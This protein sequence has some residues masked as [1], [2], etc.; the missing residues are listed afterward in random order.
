MPIC[1]TITNIF[2]PFRRSKTLRVYP[3][4]PFPFTFHSNTF[5]LGITFKNYFIRINYKGF[6]PDNK[7][8]LL[9]NF[10]CNLALSL[11]RQSLKFLSRQIKILSF[12]SLLCICSLK[13]KFCNRASSLVLDQ[14][15]HES[16]LLITFQNP[17]EASLSISVYTKY[18]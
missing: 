18:N 17:G 13:L 15:S 12:N 7:G 2:L 10:Q 8:G 6:Y 4:K 9:R 11:K 16:I 3:C 14:A 5:H 1:R